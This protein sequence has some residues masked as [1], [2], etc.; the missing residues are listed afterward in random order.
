M[1]AD[2]KTCPSARGAPGAILLGVVGS[3]GRVKPIRTPIIVDA[4]FVRA[5]SEHGP[6]EA[7]MRF[8][9]PCQTTGCQQWSRGGCGI[10]EK[11]LSHLA[12][13]DLPTGALPPCTIRGTCRWFSQRGARACSVCDLVVTDQT[14][15]AAE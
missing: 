11:V 2:A 14:A 10:V 4:D 3:D 9:S 13:P 5:A 15:I 7:R 6:P 12:V 1:E 8:A